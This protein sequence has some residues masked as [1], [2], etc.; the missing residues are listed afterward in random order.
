MN[1][2][3]HL[4]VG[5]RADLLINTNWMPK[6]KPPVTKPPRSSC[7]KAGSAGAHQKAWIDT[8]LKDRFNGL[9]R[10]E[11]KGIPGRRFRFD[12]SVCV[13]SEGLKLAVEY[14]G[15][16]GRGRSRHTTQTGYTA[17]C[18]KYNLAALHGWLV[19]RYTASNYKD[20][21]LHLDILQGKI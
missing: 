3:N 5:K 16:F 7:K 9:V 14:E 20:L 8:V 1:I 4:N 11:T 2:T 13:E 15:I 6:S 18:E 21:D 10:T 19:L 17:D 12:W